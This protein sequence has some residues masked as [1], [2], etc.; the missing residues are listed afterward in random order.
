[1]A[2]PPT[3]KLAA[4]C[5]VSPFNAFRWYNLRLLVGYASCLWHWKVL[6]VKYFMV[7]TGATPRELQDK[8]TVHLSLLD[9]DQGSQLKVPSSKVSQSGSQ[10][11]A[12]ALIGMKRQQT[13][14][15]DEGTRL[16]EEDMRRFQAR[17]EANHAFDD[18]SPGPSQ[19]VTSSATQRSSVTAPGSCLKL[20]IC[21]QD[22]GN[23]GPK[24]L[25]DKV[26]SYHLIH[27]GKLAH[28]APLL[29]SEY[30]CRCS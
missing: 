23:T 3:A 13:Q 22:G 28:S 1:M 15:A 29:S 24:E 7:L 19:Q 21:A 2:T 25:L 11:D 4:Q 27:L 16:L 17:E 20:H 10:W 5:V 8:G 6:S 12:L 14:P 26:S 9:T 30:L 18:I